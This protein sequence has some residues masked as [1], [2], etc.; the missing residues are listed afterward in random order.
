M[1]TRKLMIAN[2]RGLD[3]QA[4]A[5]IANIAKHCRCNLS[6]V[7]NGRRVK[8]RDIAGV[9]LL[10]AAMGSTVRIVADGPDEEVAIREV[11]ILFHDGLGERR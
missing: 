5:G 1:Q 11:A 6:V 2:P 4:C 3:A 8:A 7:R 10:T 9:M